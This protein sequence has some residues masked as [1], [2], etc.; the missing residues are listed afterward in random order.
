MFLGAN[1]RKI[2]GIAK[3]LLLIKINTL[4]VYEKNTYNRVSIVD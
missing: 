3:Y 4:K 1:I 2:I